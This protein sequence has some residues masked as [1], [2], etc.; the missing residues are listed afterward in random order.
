MVRPLIWPAAA[1]GSSPLAEKSFSLLYTLLPTQASELP[2]NFYLQGL[3]GEAWLSMSASGAENVQPAKK[4]KSQLSQQLPS[5][6]SP[7]QTAASLTSTW[8]W[9]AL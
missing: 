5:I 6:Q 3:C 7:F 4:P 8:T 9:W 2:D 1:T